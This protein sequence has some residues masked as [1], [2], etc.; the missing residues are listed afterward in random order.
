MNF[1]RTCT[2][3]ETYAARIMSCFNDR[4]GSPDA[5]CVCWEL[6]CFI[7]PIP[8]A[9]PLQMSFHT[10]PSRSKTILRV[11]VVA[12]CFSLC[13]KRVAL[14][15]LVWHKP[16]LYKFQCVYIEILPKRKMTD[17]RMS[18]DVPYTN[19]SPGSFGQALCNTA[20]HQLSTH[21]AI[22]AGMDVGWDDEAPLGKPRCCK[23]LYKSLSLNFTAIF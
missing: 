5:L 21:G 9:L 2:H 14:K 12:M 7:L 1:I 6:Q 13:N 22:A 10:C 17:H 3:E 18:R 23:R 16:F 4:N 11:C 19:L 15:P 20:K 8:N